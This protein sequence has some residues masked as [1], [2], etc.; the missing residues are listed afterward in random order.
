MQALSAYK[1]SNVVPFNPVDKVTQATVQCSD[2]R[3]MLACKGAP[4]VCL[5]ASAVC[6]PAAATPF[7]SV[8]VLPALPCQQLAASLCSGAKTSC[9]LCISAQGLAPQQ[10]AACSLLPAACCLQ[11]AHQSAITAQL[12]EQWCTGCEGQA[13][14]QGGHRSLRRLHHRAGISRPEG[15]GSGQEL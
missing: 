4:Q 12:T 2:G 7:T 6:V 15:S 13:C 3:T 9:C 10:P 5:L 8:L 11:P 14:R 1:I